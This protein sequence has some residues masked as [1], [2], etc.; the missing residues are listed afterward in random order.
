MTTQPD[1]PGPEG[2]GFLSRVIDTYKS[3][4]SKVT[5]WVK[6]GA[7]LYEKKYQ[8]GL[9]G[10]TITDALKGLWPPRVGFH[11]LMALIGGAIT[12]TLG[13]GRAALTAIGAFF[14][15]LSW[16]AVLAGLGIAAVLAAGGYALSNTGGTPDTAGNQ[17]QQQ[18]QPGGQEPQGG[19]E[20]PPPGG[21]PAPPP[22]PGREPAPAPP[23]GDEPAPP[24]PPG[25]EP[26]PA[27][28]P[29]GN[30]PQGTALRVKVITTESC[31]NEGPAAVKGGV[32]VRIDGVSITTGADPQS[33]DEGVGRKPVPPGTH[34][35]TAPGQIHEIRVTPTGEPAKFKTGGNGMSADFV[36]ANPGGSQ[37]DYEVAVRFKAADCP[38]EGEPAEPGVPPAPP[39]PVPPP[40]PPAPPAPPPEP[41]APLP[42]P[43]A[44]PA[45]PPAPPPEPPAPPAEPPAPPQPVQPA[46]QP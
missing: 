6:S 19:V 40:E 9:Q 42:E 25:R 21:G 18:Q 4:E 20:P 26:A 10:R 43:P 46:P 30:Q 32:T 34:T 3:I 33:N 11:N 27:P 38:A 8:L 13:W 1:Q 45:E 16:P 29:P 23:P 12:F 31:T 15:G 39:P 41:P 17:Q 44:P 28:P 7:R 35:V 14:T 36:N 37:S 24:P 22:P 5:E 2:P